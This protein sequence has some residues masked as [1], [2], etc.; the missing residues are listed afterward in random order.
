MSQI[1]II[2]ESAGVGKTTLSRELAKDYSSSIVI[3]GDDLKNFIINH[4][5]GIEKRLTYKNAAILAQSYI[6]SGFEV[7]IVD[8]VFEH[9][10]Q[11]THFKS[12]IADEIPVHVFTLWAELPIAILREHNRTGREAL[13]MQVTHSH[14]AITK[15]IDHLGHKIDTSHKSI[16]EIIHNI[17]SAIYT[18]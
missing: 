16:A 10:D 13:G 3:H 1:I 6:Q 12:F 15:H 8:F 4:P 17:K 14:Q 11:I 7:V 5:Q 18:Q 9:P 2:N